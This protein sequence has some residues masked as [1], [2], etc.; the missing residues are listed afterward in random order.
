MGSWSK[1]ARWLR[2]GDMIPDALWLEALAPLPYAAALPATEHARL[3]ALATR[4]LRNKTFEGAAGLHV[5]D[6]MRV[7]VAVQA[8][9]LILNLDF[10]YYAGWRSVILYPGDFRVA[11]EAVDPDGIVHR[12]TEELAGESWENGPVILSWDTVSNSSESV[13]LVL[14]EFAHKIDM[15]NGMADGCPPLPPEISPKDWAR[16]FKTAY[17]SLQAALE[18]G[19]PLALDVYAAESPAEFFAVSSETF[20]LQPTALAADF[21]A[22]YTQLRLFY[23]QDPGAVLGRA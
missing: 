9:L 8:C 6:S 14:H 19:A 10:D 13:G 5:T 16:D 12:W 7:R 18:R 17:Q 1:C 22:I 11:K 15:R 23:R 4:F 21:P 20:F 2:R 3:R